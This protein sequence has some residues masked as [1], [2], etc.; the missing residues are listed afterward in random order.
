MMTEFAFSER[1]KKLAAFAAI[2]FVWGSTYLAIRLLGETLPPLSMVGLRFLLAGGVLF[3]WAR[4]R[5]AL[6]PVL[7]QW[8]SA[9][10]S[11]VLL[12]CGGTGG[13]VWAVQ[14][15][16]SGMVA[17]LVGTEPLWLALLLWIWPGGR[18][19]T[20][21]TWGA[22]ALGFCGAAILAAPNGG[23]TDVIR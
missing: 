10:V 21:A 9:S 1:A 14:H 16:D 12:L 8:R 19:P 7:R 5:G 17:L 4:W 6:M 3:A 20:L 2:Y 18:R 22:L 15:L 23:S 13:V 11:G